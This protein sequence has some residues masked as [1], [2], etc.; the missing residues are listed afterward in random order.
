MSKGFD[1]LMEGL[2]EAKQHIDG[3]KKAP[4]RRFQVK[5]VRPLTAEEFKELRT[6]AGLSQGVLA[7]FLGVSSKTVEA[8]ESKT[9]KIP[10]PVSRV[11]PL[12][13]E[14]PEYFERKEI[15]ISGGRSLTR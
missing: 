3:V 12:L 6:Q 13:A 11:L 2:R 10:G 8:W 15:L 9:N 4:V 14:D 7:I 1:I 5:P